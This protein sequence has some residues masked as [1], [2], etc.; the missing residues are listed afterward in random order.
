[1]METARMPVQ[2]GRGRE[3]SLGR[4]AE[5]SGDGGVEEQPWDELC[6]LSRRGPFRIQLLPAF[7][8]NPMGKLGVVMV[9]DILFSL[10]PISVVV[11]D[12]FTGSTN[13][14]HRSQR[15]TMVEGMSQ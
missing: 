5:A 2:N 12:L 13:R 1:M 9:T 7:R 8:A 11:A 14:Q 4:R 6:D 3:A 15:F 10:L